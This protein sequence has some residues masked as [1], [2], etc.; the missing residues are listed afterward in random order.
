MNN[1]TAQKNNDIWLYHF[2]C[3]K[4]R[5]IIK[6]PRV[7][8]SAARSLE[9]FGMSEEKTRKRNSP[10][11]FL[12]GRGLR[13]QRPLHEGNI[14]FAPKFDMPQLLSLISEH[15]FFWPKF[16]KNFAKRYG[17]NWLI[18]CRLAD[19][20][21]VNPGNPARCCRYNSGAPRCSGGRKSPRGP[22]L[23][24]PLANV[25]RRKVVEIVFRGSVS[26]PNDC[27][28]FSPDE[29]QKKSRADNW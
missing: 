5:G 26:L 21:K 25:P 16:K 10:L 11:C 1:T 4:K 6:R 20:E 3:S 9:A 2:M 13:D 8:F 23:F 19:L 7:L 22:D 28:F 27:E 15:V 24:E 12:D 14:A 18:R 29:W 17:D